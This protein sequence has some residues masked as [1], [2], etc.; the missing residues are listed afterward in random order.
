MGPLFF[1]LPYFRRS[2]R[3]PVSIESL[4]RQRFATLSSAR[5][6]MAVVVAVVVVVVV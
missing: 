3:G 6:S 5:P 2:G 1:P 4:H